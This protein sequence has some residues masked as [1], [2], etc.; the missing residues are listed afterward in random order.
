MLF[1]QLCFIW[2]I[3]LFTGFELVGGLLYVDVS[4]FVVLYFGD[5]FACWIY[6]FIVFIRFGVCLNCLSVVI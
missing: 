1:I 6:T 5:Y 3:E 2:A 4:A